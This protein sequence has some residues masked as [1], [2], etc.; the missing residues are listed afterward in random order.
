MKITAAQASGKQIALFSAA[1]LVLAVVGLLQLYRRQPIA[2]AVECL[3]VP[4]N[5]ETLGAP[6]SAVQIQEGL[7]V[8]ARYSAQVRELLAPGV[9]L[10]EFGTGVTGGHLALRDQCYIGQAV[11][12][13]R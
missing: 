2:L 1:L 4:S 10:R 11:A 9:T 3:P 13:V 5:V 7:S 12:W 8:P 6:L